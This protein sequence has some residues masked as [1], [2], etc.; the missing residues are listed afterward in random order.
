MADAE[1]ASAFL[2]RA[3]ANGG[4][5]RIEDG[6][7]K[8]VKGGICSRSKSSPIQEPADHAENWKFPEKTRFSYHCFLFCD[9]SDRPSG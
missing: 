3:K 5:A 2:R 8:R 6:K 9:Q 7:V 4:R 1:E